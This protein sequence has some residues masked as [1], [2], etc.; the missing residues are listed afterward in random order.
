MTACE[1]GESIDHRTDVCAQLGAVCRI[2]LTL[3]ALRMEARHGADADDETAGSAIKKYSVLFAEPRRAAG[4]Q[5]AEHPAESA[6]DS[7]I[8]D[9]CWTDP[10]DERSALR[11]K[12]ENVPDRDDVLR[13]TGA[14][15]LFVPTETKV[16]S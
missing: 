13:K 5:S 11:N 12:R 8:D 1:R 15:M 9:P 2:A 4:A 10:A 3:K 14:S 7:F 16:V 6:S